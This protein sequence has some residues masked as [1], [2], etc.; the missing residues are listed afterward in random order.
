MVMPRRAQRG[1]GPAGPRLGHRA[2]IAAAWHRRW[3][4]PAGHGGRSRPDRDPRVLTA[5]TAMGTD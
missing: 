4:R 1:G 2:T 3:P 5:W